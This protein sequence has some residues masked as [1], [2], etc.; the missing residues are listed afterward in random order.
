MKEVLHKSEGLEKKE[1]IGHGKIH[2]KIRNRD[3]IIRKQSA[4]KTGKNTPSGMG[5]A[6]EGR[7]LWIICKT[8]ETALWNMTKKMNK[9][10]TNQKSKIVE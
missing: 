10:Q 1:G 6:K 4:E 8:G 5:E 9:L 2:K 7:N 3:L